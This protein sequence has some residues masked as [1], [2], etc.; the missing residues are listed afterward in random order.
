M[1]NNFVPQNSKTFWYHKRF[2]S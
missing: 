1:H 2:G